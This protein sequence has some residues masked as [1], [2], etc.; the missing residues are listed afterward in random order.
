MI[1]PWRSAT[2]TWDPFS[3]LAATEGLRGRAFA[4]QPRPAERPL[5]ALVPSIS[6]ALGD[7]L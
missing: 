3:V 6:A 1:L 7:N 4:S 5:L 2:D